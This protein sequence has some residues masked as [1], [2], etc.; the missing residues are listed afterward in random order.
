MVYTPRKQ[1]TPKITGAPFPGDFYQPNMAPKAAVVR[2]SGRGEGFYHEGQQFGEYAGK[3]QAP[4]MV[5]AHTVHLPRGALLSPCTMWRTGKDTRPK[6]GPVMVPVVTAAHGGEAL[7]M[8]ELHRDV[9][10]GFHQGQ[11]AGKDARSGLGQGNMA[12]PHQGFY[13]G[14]HAGKDTRSGLG[15][16]M[17]PMA[18]AARGEAFGDFYQGLHAGKDTRSHLGPGLVPLGAAPTPPT[19][20]AERL[21]KWVRRPMPAYAQNTY[22]KEQKLPSGPGPHTWRTP[23]PCTSPSVHC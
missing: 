5:H 1:V 4:H 21:E 12:D 18:A 9:Y 20:Q 2:T 17:V 16:G 7:N 22:S 10:Q 15:Q 13:Q 3:D 19:P 6:V 8:A 23:T 14:L 11:H